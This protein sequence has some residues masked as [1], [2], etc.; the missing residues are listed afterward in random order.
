MVNGIEKDSFRIGKMKFG[1][2]SYADLSWELSQ[3]LRKSTQIEAQN[4]Q[5]SESG[6]R[7]PQPCSGRSW[8]ER[9]RWERSRLRNDDDSLIV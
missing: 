9:N 1:L 7:N 5:G 3:L 4:L 2:A 8:L 6:G